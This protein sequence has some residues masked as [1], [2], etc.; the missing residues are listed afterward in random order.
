M[1]ELVREYLGELRGKQKKR[2][3]VGIIVAAFAV[4]I[5]G[6]VIW[7]LIQSGIAMT[8]EPKCG[9]EEHAHSDVCYTSTLVCGQE[10]STGHQHTDACFE[11]QSTLVCGLEESEAS[12][13]S[14]GH[15]H[16]EECYTAEQ[17]LICGQ[18]ESM[19]HTHTDECSEN[20]QTCGK[21]EHTHDDFCYI[22][23]NADV[24]DASSW[25][26]LYQNVEWKDAWG[27]DLVTAA[28][29]QVGYKEST[30]NYM[31]AEDGSHKGYTRYGQFAGDVYADWDAPFVNFC[32]HYAGMEAPDL[33]PG[34]KV[35]AEWYDKFIKTS[36]TNQN[37]ITAPEG[38]EPKAGDIVFF[39]KDGEETAFQMGIVSSYNNEKYELEVIEGNS[40]NEVKE[41]KY[42]AGDEHIASY[43]MVSEL[44]K[45][46]KDNGEEQTPAEE[47]TTEEP[48]V[49]ADEAVTEEAAE[50]TIEQAKPSAYEEKY[51]DDIIV[52]HVSAAEGVVP[53]GAELSVTPIEQKKVTREMSEEE[54]AEVEK[55]N[56]QYE[57]TNQ[58]LLEE[59]EK[60]QETL[61]GF[62]AY[63]ICF[64]VDGEETEPS[65]DVKVTM[66]FK[67]AVKPEGVS[68][69]AT[70]AVNHLKEDEDAADGVVVEDLT[71]K[72]DTTIATAETDTSV[73]K[74]EL[75]A[76]SFSTFA[77]LW[78]YGDQDNENKYTPQM[79]IEYVN[80][81]GTPIAYEGNINISIEK[82]TVVDLR[83]EV[84]NLIKI[85]EDYYKR[86]DIRVVDRR[87]EESNSV[88][89]VSAQ[90]GDNW[91]AQAVFYDSDEKPYEYL[92]I[93]ILD[94]NIILRVVYNKS[95]GIEIV[96]D[97]VQSG[98]IKVEG[99][100]SVINQPL[101]QG[102]A[103][104]YV[105][106]KQI[107]GASY[108]KVQTIVY[109]NK[110]ANISDSGKSLN[111]AL[112]KGALNSEQKSVNYK[113]ELQI[114]D[115]S[116]EV[117]YS[118]ESDPFSIMYYS[119]VQNG[120]FERPALEA[121]INKFRWISEDEV[122]GWKTTAGNHE[123]EIVCPTPE[124]NY[125]NSNYG[126]N[127]IPPAEGAQFAEINGHQ[128]HGAL[129]QDVL[130]IKDIPLNYYF[131]HR[132]RKNAGT[133]RGINKIYV[134]IM[135]TR[136]AQAGVS[137][138][139]GEIDTREEV[140]KVKDDPEKYDAYVE[141]F[142]SGTSWVDYQDEYIPTDSLTR[143]FF[144]SA[145]EKDP[146]MGNYLDN[147]W[148]GQ[149]IPVPSSNKFNLRIEKNVANL[150]YETF[151]KLKSEL[152]F[153]IEVKDSN[154]T[155]VKD[156]TGT[157]ALLTGKAVTL[158]AESMTWIPNSDGTYTGI[159]DYKNNEITGTY[160]ISVTENK[161]ELDGY[162]VTETSKHTVTSLGGASV[163][164]IGSTDI[165]VSSK[166]AV[167]VAFTNS[168]E[169][170][171]IEPDKVKDIIFTKIWDDFEDEY[172]KRPETLQ[173]KL[174]GSI[175]GK[176]L[177]DDQLAALKVDV[178][179]LTQTIT[180]KS[181]WSYRWENIPVYYGKEKAVINWSVEEILTDEVASSY[182]QKPAGKSEKSVSLL[183]NRDSYTEGEESEELSIINALDDDLLR[184][185]RMVK[186]S[187][188]SREKTLEGAE[189]ELE[190]SRQSLLEV[191]K[192]NIIAVGKS[193]AEGNI[194]W[195]PTDSS[196][197]WETVKKELNGEYVIRETKAPAGYSLSNT[198]WEI[199]FVNGIPN[200]SRNQNNIDK[201]KT[202]GK[203]VFYIGNTALYALPDAGGSGIYWY[204]F[205][206]ILLMAGAALITYKKRCR[207]V[208]RS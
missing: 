110:M 41:N 82:E 101:Y 191:E 78:I 192:T 151:S 190:E 203:I 44:E 154:G 45:V 34:E 43:L 35:T 68:E 153:N 29:A 56:E 23:T 174:A 10:E 60:K 13:E 161:K 7:G 62:L 205:S 49:P 180:G 48:E 142:T 51:E 67:E 150:D 72:D 173:I 158:K 33:F 9:V 61:E 77:I 97:I 88:V 145:E 4:I 172:K 95:D 168:Y 198:V 120:G 202:D 102:K 89:K 132:A 37:Y 75:V 155:F 147:V 165:S 55:V 123:I 157:N 115:D 124:N 103:F 156:S 199:E 107:N 121:D 98:N 11:T 63:D 1:Q 86:V 108:E 27:E 100:E 139:V 14:E 130:T 164:D 159:Y 193:D 138:G 47:G 186:H 3:R 5:V 118:V 91:F 96:D 39:N 104:G 197:K 79:Q 113:V 135:P 183:N 204:M 169:V 149:E 195:E 188:S 117:I 85:E 122:D 194:K 69:N 167:E 170:D 22:D 16:G 64:I 179:S 52:I 57:L 143:F 187:S 19:G 80:S 81:E 182:T 109:E 6:G 71:R 184:D 148:F 93:D 112:D 84:P 146:T 40:G 176:A 94:G 70:V 116:G 12:E 125:V 76:E 114:Y 144:V 87:T 196:K 30:K 128:F 26:A 25:Y 42:N 46:C 17:V 32:M 163:E 74:V 175:N 83:K 140:L 131:S 129:Y 136:V 189:F 65:G 38:Y 106:Y 92:P 177:T 24:E 127:V 58:K 185:W 181:D 2:R 126:E 31:V 99:G 15:V 206:G 200:I 105:W 201:D 50:E 152:E 28:K 53:E 18:E 66:D 20:Q 160:E 141:L 133:T 8:G 178:E 111:V 36:E 59:S 73:E 162:T 171:D 21:E 119:E 134:V 90:S 54:A 166:Q 137:G 208:L 207:E